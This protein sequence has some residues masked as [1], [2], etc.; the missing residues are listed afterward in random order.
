MA[1]PT[2]LQ[3]ALWY[4]DLGYPV[5]PCAPGRKTPATPHGLLDATTDVEQIGRWWTEQPSANVAIRTDGLLVV[6]VDGAENPWLHD[7]AERRAEIAIAPTSQTPRGGRQYFFRQ[8][9]GRTWRNTAGRLADHVDTRGNGGY[10]LVAPSIVDGRG[11]LWAED[12]PLAVT[13]PRLPEPPAWL[14]TMLD[15]LAASNSVDTAVDA[16]RANPIPEGQRNAT[17]ARLAGAMRRVGMT[18]AELFAALLQINVD[19]CTPPLPLREVERIAASVARYEPDSISVALIEDHWRQDFAPKPPPGPLSV[20][21]L[22]RTYTQLRAPII[23]GL[24]RRGETMNVIAPPKTGK[25]WL[26][27]GLAMAVASG[28]R[29]LDTFETTASDVLIIDNELHLQTLAHR[30]PQVAEGLSIGLDE[31]G[32]TIHLHSLRGQLRDI[33]ALR[34]YFDAIEPGRFGLIVLD[35]MYRFMPR[36]MDENDNGT[37]AGIY[38]HIDALADRLACSFV[39]IHHATKGN[40]STK[41]VT[42][43]GAGAGSQSRATDTHLVLR[44]HE[45][46][47]AV[48]L[49]AAVRS[50]PPVEPLSLRWTFPIWSPATELDPT[51]LRVEKPKRRPSEVADVPRAEQVQEFVRRFVTAEPQTRSTLLQAA[52]GGGLSGRSAQRLLHAAEELGLIHR[53][54][55]GSH[56]PTCFATRA[57]PA[58]GGD[59]D[60]A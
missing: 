5:F 31:I 54:S 8:P 38:N 21:T 13:P 12:R 26:V 1:A 16:S 28:R 14:T 19:R 40:Q 39:L 4:A 15:A 45:E 18:R 24:L 27:L 55:F 52:T 7:D 43:V 59:R 25:S 56:R 46:P 10:V 34:E 17:L 57:K 60:S 48:V 6:D 42:D 51:R 30:I 9:K 53:W 41:A 37:M 11:Y 2:M 32:E 47:G 49:D 35:A 29:W 58:K 23:H 22:L 20:R 33:F 36:E 50:W 44:P 3:T